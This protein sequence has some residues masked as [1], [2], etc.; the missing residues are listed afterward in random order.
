MNRIAKAWDSSVRRLHETG[1]SAFPE[2]LLPLENFSDYIAERFETAEGLQ[3]LT[4]AEPIASPADLFLACACALELPQSAEAFEQRFAGD[5]RAILARYDAHG[6]VQEDAARA[7]IAGLLVSTD[8]RPPKIAQ[9]RGRG[10]LLAFLRIVVVREA[11]MRLRRQ[12]KLVSEELLADMPS[13]DDPELA[14]LKQTYQ[15]EFREAFAVAVEGLEPRQRTL[16]RYHLVDQLNSDQV[17]AIY[18]VH[19]ATAAR[20]VSAAR[21]T[22]LES[23]RRALMEKLTISKD[24]FESI[25]RLIQSS[26]DV[27]VQRLLGTDD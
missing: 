21:S 25:M 4:K 22:L 7:A 16:L 1:Q 27:S 10:Q 23:T 24:E 14:Y 18:A 19:R 2:L 9:Y 12:K 5:I 17:A 13:A 26:F 3:Q 8:S 6:S 20:W 15:S 11:L